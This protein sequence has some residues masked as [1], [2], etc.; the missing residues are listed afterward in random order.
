M[1]SGSAG[2]VRRATEAPRP[3]MPEAAKPPNP[4]RVRLATCLLAACIAAGSP[5]GWASG[6]DGD[7]TPPTA[8]TDLSVVGA[9]QSSISFTWTSSTDDVG[10]AG[11]G[12][13]VNTVQVDRAWPRSYTAA[14]PYTLTGLT[15]GS[16][17]N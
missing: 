11:Y 12:V 7:T 14:R 5:V 15:C 10:V 2:T 8:P 6:A 17:L 3:E 13:Y 16:T 4:V 1:S 9:T